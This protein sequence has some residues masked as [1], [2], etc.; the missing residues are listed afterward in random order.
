MFIVMNAERLAQ[1]VKERR[2]QLG[3]KQSD[4]A[5]LSS[6]AQHTLS[7]LESGRGNPT[8]QVMVQVLE[9]LGLQLTLVVARS[10]GDANG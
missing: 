5:E 2:R 1:A 7:N 8:L 3:L 9:A 10:E 6:V 4:L